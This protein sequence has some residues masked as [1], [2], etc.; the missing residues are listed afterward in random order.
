MPLVLIALF[1]LASPTFIAPFF[2]SAVGIGLLAL[3]LV[4]QVTGILLVRR[5]LSAG[6]ACK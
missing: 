4:M 5:A 6:G 2:G 1:S 3:A